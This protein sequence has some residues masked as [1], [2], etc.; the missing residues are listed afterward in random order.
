MSLFILFDTAEKIKDIAQTTDLVG[1]ILLLVILLAVLA[2]VIFL[3]YFQ[4]K[5]AKPEAVRRDENNYVKAVG[6]ITEVK[7]FEYSVIPYQ[8]EKAIRQAISEE[9]GMN[10]EVEKKDKSH[11]TGLIGILPRY[12]YDESKV[13]KINKVRYD[14]KYEFTVSESGEAYKGTFSVY[15]E[16]DD[17]AEGKSIDVMYNPAKP[18]ANYTQYN[19]PIGRY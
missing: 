7:K 12:T 8:Q 9:N 19:S 10:G 13:E 15:E 11:D 16:K 1:G 2:A 5:H 17:V 3:I 18:T 6:K 14:V 4:K